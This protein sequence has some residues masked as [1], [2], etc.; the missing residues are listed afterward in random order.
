ML[1]SATQAW[2]HAVRPVEHVDE[3]VPWLQTCEPLHALVQAPQCWGSDE[4]STQ[5]K[6]PCHGGIYARD[7]QVVSGPPPRPLE[8][9]NSRVNPS[10]GDIEVEL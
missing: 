9:L 1:V 5:F 10:T 2:P 7:G 8:R 6:C 4:T 3:H